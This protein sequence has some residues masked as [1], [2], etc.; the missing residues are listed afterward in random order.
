MN[1]LWELFQPLQKHKDSLENLQFSG[2]RQPSDA[3][4]DRLPNYNQV[5]VQGIDGK[6]TDSRPYP[7]M[8]GITD[9]LSKNQDQK[10]IKDV[11]NAAR[12]DDYLEDSDAYNINWNK[13]TLKD[14][15][16]LYRYNTFKQ[17]QY[18][19]PPRIDKYTRQLY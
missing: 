7:F 2:I 5:Y 6:Y 4:W 17:Q 14:L 15:L 11:W 18:P 19:P 8:R 1:N 12:G 13:L 9:L 16:S 10:T 3:R